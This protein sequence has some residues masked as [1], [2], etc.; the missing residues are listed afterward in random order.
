MQEILNEKMSQLSRKETFLLS[1]KWSVK[2]ACTATCGTR[3][4]GLWLKLP[5]VL[6]NVCANSEGPG[7]TARM[8][9]LACVFAAHL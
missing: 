3:S 6:Y 5:L 1:S 4:S 9:R 7:K 8:Y 2:R